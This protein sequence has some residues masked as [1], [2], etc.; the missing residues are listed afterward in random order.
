MQITSSLALNIATA[1][2]RSP[3]AFA[4][5][6][7]HKQ[8]LEFAVQLGAAGMTALDTGTLVKVE[9]ETETMLVE[10]RHLNGL[11]AVAEWVEP[12]SSEAEVLTQM[13][14]RLDKGSSFTAART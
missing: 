10:D 14:E 2:E 13:V 8:A 3:D 4:S 6:H 1:I 5:E 9:F 11:R 12:T 7:Q